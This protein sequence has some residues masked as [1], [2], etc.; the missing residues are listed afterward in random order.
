M[1]QTGRAE[2]DIAESVM[3]EFEN[4]DTGVRQAPQGIQF[5][6]RGIAALTVVVAAIF[7]LGRE[8]FELGAVLALVLG[9][10]ALIFAIGSFRIR[11]RVMLC[12]ISVVVPLV[13]VL[14]GTLAQTLVWGIVYRITWVLAVFPAAATGVAIAMVWLVR[15][16]RQLV[17]LA[18]LTV[19]PMFILLAYRFHATSA[20]RWVLHKFG[21]REGA[22]WVGQ[23]FTFK[24]PGAYGQDLRRSEES[25]W[26]GLQSAR[27][28]FGL[29]SAGGLTIQQPLSNTE[30]KQVGQLNQLRNVQLRGIDVDASAF[31]ELAK[32]ENL[33]EL[34]FSDCQVDLQFQA[35]NKL[36]RLKTVAFFN[37]TLRRCDSLA[38]LQS[39][40]FLG[41]YEQSK[42]EESKVENVSA[43]IE[44][45]VKLPLL[46][47]LS[48]SS[49]KLS[50]DDLQQVMLA[51]K[52]HHQ[53]GEYFWLEYFQVDAKQVEIKTLIE[54]FEQS[55]Q[56]A[57]V[58]GRSR[59][60]GLVLTEQQHLELQ[61]RLDQI[62][63]FVADPKQ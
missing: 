21:T 23:K 6:M 29:S 17:S 27:I 26:Y 4:A 36:N 20:E 12:A 24:L 44:Q 13:S 53:D 15:S 1:R 61:K 49:I 56:K 45:I 25:N 28:L 9:P 18:I 62:D 32:L 10:A 33:E 47:S 51:K 50:T 8:W 5:D 35:T 14:A 7:G 57:N 52:L 60:H 38:N 63:G 11:N 42:A 40:E 30:W 3:G 43:L 41:L 48:A 31:N 37:S 54:W 59:E 2:S 39:L 16:K 34:V 19:V 46:K 55:K 22:G 58:S